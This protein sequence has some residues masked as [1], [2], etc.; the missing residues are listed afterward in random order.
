MNIFIL[1]HHHPLDSLCLDGLGAITALFF[2]WTIF[3]CVN[4]LTFCLC[5]ILFLTILFSFLMH[6]F[7]KILPI[8]FLSVFH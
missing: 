5:L 8:S 2:C 7:M 6:P 1:H 3:H 4:F